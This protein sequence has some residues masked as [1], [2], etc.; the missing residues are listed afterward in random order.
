VVSRTC[1]PLS[2][3]NFMHMGSNIMNREIKI[4]PNWIELAESLKFLDESRLKISAMDKDIQSLL[5]GQNIIHDLSSLE[6]K[7]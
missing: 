4:S 7:I 6:A 2:D 1:R 3:D 5:S